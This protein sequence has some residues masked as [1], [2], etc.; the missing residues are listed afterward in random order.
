MY[1][2]VAEVTDGPG[3]ERVEST[4][5]LAVLIEFKPQISEG[6][7]EA[8]RLGRNLDGKNLPV[9]PKNV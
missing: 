4:G 7:A 2:S 8:V 1:I 9:P 6:E 3:N 5:L